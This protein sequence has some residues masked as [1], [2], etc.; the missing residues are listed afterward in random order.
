MWNGRRPA[1]PKYVFLQRQGFLHDKRDRN[2]SG[3]WGGEEGGNVNTCGKVRITSDV[4]SNEDDE[5]FAPTIRKH[6]FIYIYF[7]IYIK[8]ASFAAPPSFGWYVD[9]SELEGELHHQLSHAPRKYNKNKRERKKNSFTDLIHR[10]SGS[11][12][13]PPSGSICS[14][15][16]IRSQSYIFFRA[17]DRRD[18]G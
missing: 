5:L 7:F 6:V 1:S 15:Q 9:K 14:Q 8:I 13:C 17:Q 2:R 3:S 4:G 11:Y 10:I 12:S 18:I 16:C